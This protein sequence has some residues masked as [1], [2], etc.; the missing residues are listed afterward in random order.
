MSNDIDALNK[1]N[2]ASQ[3]SPMKKGEGNSMQLLLTVPHKQEADADH[4]DL[5]RS[6]YYSKSS[7]QRMLARKKMSDNEKQSIGKITNKELDYNEHVTINTYKR[8]IFDY[9]GGWRFIIVSNLGIITF[10]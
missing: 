10:T 5:L 8:Y 6:R 2:Q 3:L 7:N 9:F 1:L 4:S